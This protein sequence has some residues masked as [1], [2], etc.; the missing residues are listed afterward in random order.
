MANEQNLIPN[1]ERTPEQLRAQTRKGGIRSGEVRRKTAMMR[2]EL[3]R[4]LKQKGTDGKTYKELTT[5]GLL[6]G[7]IKGNAANYKTI[8][9][10]LGE[11]QTQ[12][13]QPN[14]TPNITIN[15]VDNSNLEKV[16]Y[17]EEKNNEDK[18]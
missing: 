12:N 2:K 11:L 15:V 5:L 16:M 18:R 1:S 13:E 4:L 9:E 6:E 7:A 14:D 10:M 17:D 8:V 3:E